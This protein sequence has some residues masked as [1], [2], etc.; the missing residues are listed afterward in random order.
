MMFL[1]MQERETTVDQV[2][3]A[4][5]AMEIRR[6]IMKNPNTTRLSSFIF[7]LDKK[8]I[9]QKKEDRIKKSKSFWLAALGLKGAD[10][11]S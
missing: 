5:I 10:A 3:M 4:Q 1:D 7:D 6:T 8:V 2:Y 9:E 11:K